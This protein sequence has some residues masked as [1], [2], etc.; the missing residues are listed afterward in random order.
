MWLDPIPSLIY[1]DELAEK[2]SHK[3]ERFALNPIVGEYD[4]PVHQE[5]GI[6]CVPLTG[7]G[8][9]IIYGSAGSGKEM[10]VE[11]M[12]YSLLSAHSPSEVNIYMLDFGAE[13]LAV[14][15]AAP[16]V[17]DVVLSF[18]TEKINNLFKLLLGKLEERKKLLAAYGG[19]MRTFN[20]EAEKPEPNIVLIINNF[21]AFNELYDEKSADVNFLTREGTKYGIYF[22]VTCIGIMDV[23]FNLLQNFANSY[24]LQLNN[25]GDYSSIVGKT[26]GLQ[27]AKHKGRGL[28]QK[29]KNGLFEFQ[30]ASITARTLSA[31]F[32]R[33]FADEMVQR[34]PDT[35]AQSI[36]ILPETVTEQFL[37]PYVKDDLS[38]VPIGVEKET[39][40]VSYYDFTAC[41][42]N[43]VLS[44][45]QEWQNFTDALGKLFSGCCKKKT[46][47]FAPTG[48]TL[49][50][51]GETL[52]I[53]ND[54]DSCV[55]AVREIFE[56]IRSRNNEYKDK[57]EAGE[58]PPQYEH[59]FVLVQSMLLLKTML[60][61]YKPDE[62]DIKETDY[63]TPLLRLQL[64]MAKCESAYNVHFI[65]AESAANL[66]QFTVESWYKTHITGN[67]GIWVGSGISSQYR[68]K[69]NAYP[70]DYNAEIG[71][72][73]GFV[74]Q[75]SAI[76]SVKFLQ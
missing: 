21:A 23:R 74:I 49:I 4:D 40:S 20:N 70:S 36:P 10:F 75:N 72:D 24:C 9:V 28:I 15:S 55:K 8:N 76:A 62:D 39:L 50:Q 25:S 35:K 46:M 61:R 27:P 63:D 48:K 1:V 6:L 52:Q 45:N 71:S 59:I 43:I 19:D 16:H 57:L 66:T 58:K 11:A 26:D 53:F 41:P 44:A 68:L 42:V 37:F 60:E 54:I 34:Y 30:T 22:V 3:T 65:V 33:E 67:A 29:D 73:F 13:R 5:Q 64:A 69:I 17:G 18:E 14:F 56:I 7:D 47:V 2:Y 32:I 38:R 51:S 12:C 31:D